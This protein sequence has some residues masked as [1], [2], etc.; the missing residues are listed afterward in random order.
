MTSERY[1]LAAPRVPEFVHFFDG[2]PS[3]SKP[4]DGYWCYKIVDR[5]GVTL[6]FSYDI[7]ER[8]VQTQI[9]IGNDL[10]ETVSR[11][12]AR[13]I[14]IE[15]DKLVVTFEDAGMKTSL[16]VQVRPTIVVVWSGVRE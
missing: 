10:V 8:S 7:F 1:Y 15:D 6:R 11:E 16:S 9:Y 12:A 4:D 13:E 3:E 14:R 2:Q 5:R